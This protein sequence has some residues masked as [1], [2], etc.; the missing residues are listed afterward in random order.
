[1]IIRVLD[2]GKDAAGLTRYLF[3]PGKANEHT[4]QRLVAGS[5]ELH[6][7]W[8]G[9][10]LSMREAT[11]LG[12]IVEMNWRRQYVPELAVAGQGATGVSRANLASGED[13]V[14]GQAHVFHAALSLHRD[15]GQLSDEQWQRVA[16]E[17]VRG[18]GFV[19]QEG[20]PDASW[21][22][23]HHGVS[24]EGN[25]HIH[26]VVCTTL[27]DGSTVNTGNTGRRSQQVRR[28][29]LERLDFVTPLHDQDRQEN[30]P[31]I[32]GYTAAEHNM[33]RDR[34]AKTEGSAIPDR[35]QLQRIVRAAAAQSTTEAGF[36]N[37]VLSHPGVEINAARWA[38]GGAETV[39]GYT[40][41][42]DG[43]AAFPASKLA[44]DLT[45]SK[46]R[47]GWTEET[48]ETKQLALELWRGD[49]SK[50]DPLVA[51]RDVPH[52][53]ER[54]AAELGRFNDELAQLDL[55]DKA[56]W[57][58]AQE[59][60]AGTATVLATGR[61]VG[62]GANG[63]AAGFGPDAGRAADAL[64]RQALAERSNRTP[65]G[66]PSVP[67]GLSGAE[68]AT[69]HVQLALRAG[70]TNRNRGWLAVVQQINRAADTMRQAKEARGE[71]LAA[72]A[73]RRDVTASFTRLEEYLQT[74][75]AD[76]PGAGSVAA[77]ARTERASER[78]LRESFERTAGTDS[79]TQQ[80][81]MTEDARRAAEIAAHGRGDAPRT[82]PDAPSATPSVKPP[83]GPD[84]SLKK[85]RG[86]GP[87]P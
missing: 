38:P 42:L 21:M 39:T 33:A 79:E 25:D 86:R 81:P 17:Y 30:A 68:V 24:T 54:A 63:R 43:G 58:N 40:V 6:A 61:P 5:V 69:R 32:K 14:P 66:A 72:H 29:V 13:A 27:R 37:A 28:D 2:M 35:V 26:V 12:R 11:Q 62:V 1:M 47:P 20:R 67:R 80:T 82:A 75:V 16:D 52:Q 74:T 50:L 22:A 19:G 4:N 3:G 55:N 31:T 8:G 51:T 41:S 23:V 60:L 87:R 34:A 71:L 64:A 78:L 49:A 70:G 46:L 36:I 57:D 48:P 45:L 15:E 73:L 76:A 65:Y 77:P 18:M 56:A 83:S 44:S 59:S 53:L 85:G 10:A 7:E 9:A 84:E